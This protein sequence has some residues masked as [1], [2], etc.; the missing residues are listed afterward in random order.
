MTY[1]KGDEHTSSHWLKQQ[2]EYDKEVISFN[3]SVPLTAENL[4]VPAGT[5]LTISN[6]GKGLPDK[7]EFTMELHFEGQIID[8]YPVS[9]EDVQALADS[10]IVNTVSDNE[11]ERDL[12]CLLN[13]HSYDDLS[14][15]LPEEN[16]LEDE[17]GFIRLGSDYHD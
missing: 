14:G 17:E 13:Q 7:G 1:K 3:S 9:L 6:G 5:S 15:W 8:V 16:I 12:S 2:E 4:T 10:A 11:I